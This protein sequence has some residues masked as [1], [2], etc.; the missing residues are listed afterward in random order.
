MS[1]SIQQCLTSIDKASQYYYT[2]THVH[3]SWIAILSFV[4]K[5]CNTAV[6]TTDI[7]EK[8]VLCIQ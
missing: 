8:N 4:M 3:I 2:D 1:N 6:F 5:Y 7:Y